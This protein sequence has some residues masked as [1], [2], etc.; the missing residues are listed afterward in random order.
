MKLATWVS[1][2][3]VAGEKETKHELNDQWCTQ[4]VQGCHPS[5]TLRPKILQ[6]FS[7]LFRICF[8]SC[9]CIITLL[10]SH[11]YTVY[12]IFTCMYMYDILYVHMQVAGAWLGIFVH[13]IF[14]TSQAV[15]HLSCWRGVP[16]TS[17]LSHRICE[18]LI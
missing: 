4:G 6:I 1:C 11:L 15:N 5:Q 8:F 3:S 7:K 12:V 18:N 14:T 2:S 9:V 16:N 13:I 17:S 10:Y